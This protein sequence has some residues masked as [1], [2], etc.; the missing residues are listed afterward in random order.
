MSDFTHP[1]V[2]EREQL[3]AAELDEAPIAVATPL[4]QLRAEITAPVVAAPITLEVPG[5]T[6]YAVRYLTDLD[7]DQVDMWRR[8]STRRAPGKGQTQEINTLKLAELILAHQCEAII[9]QGADVVVDD[10]PLV[11]ASRT[12]MAIT[13]TSKVRDAVRKFYGRDADVISAGDAV[14]EAAGYLDTAEEVEGAS[15]RLDP[16]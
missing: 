13:G 14:L 11:F 9:R 10:E 3:L 4:D 1:G 12:M 15:E 7:H 6:G 8:Q 5:R 2:S 16:T